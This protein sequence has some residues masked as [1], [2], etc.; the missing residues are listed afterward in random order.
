[1]K[2]LV[3]D[4]QVEQQEVEQTASNEGGVVDKDQI[5]L[6][7]QSKRTGAYIGI[8]WQRGC[9]NVS[10]CTYEVLCMLVGG[11]LPLPDMNSTSRSILGVLMNVPALRYG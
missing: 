2:L 11:P 5:T 4:D 7:D 10:S 1:M 6:R 9:L 3:P 8:C